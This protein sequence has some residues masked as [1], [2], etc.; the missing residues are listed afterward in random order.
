MHGHLSRWEGP[1][2]LAAG[3]TTLRDMGNDNANMQLMIDEIAHDQLLAQNGFYARLHS[4]GLDEG[5]PLGPAARNVKTEHR[6]RPARPVA[7]TRS[8]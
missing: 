8:A 5:A 2:H 7:M 6:T 3:V 1:L 4:M